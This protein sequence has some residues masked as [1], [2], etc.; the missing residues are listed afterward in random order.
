MILEIKNCMQ[1]ASVY[2]ACRVLLSVSLG[3]TDFDPLQTSVELG[4]VRHKY[5]SDYRALRSTPGLRSR[6]AGVGSKTLE[7]SLE[8]LAL[9]ITRPTIFS[10]KP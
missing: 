6:A 3:M 7:L 1:N 8:Q 10:T 2:F 4:L 5:G 9:L